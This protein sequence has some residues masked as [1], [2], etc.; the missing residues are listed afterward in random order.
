MDLRGRNWIEATTRNASMQSIGKNTE[1]RDVIY[2]VNGKA[3]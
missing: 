2:T 3:S 1:E